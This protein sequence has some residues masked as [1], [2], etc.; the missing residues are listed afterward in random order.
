MGC[1]WLVIAGVIFE[2]AGFVLVAY[3]LTRIQRREFGKPAVM[4]RLR[5]RMGQLIRRPSVQVEEAGVA[6]LTG[7][8]IPH[9]ES[10]AQR[11]PED[12]RKARLESLEKKTHQLQAEVDHRNA[13]FGGDIEEPSKQLEKTRA[14]LGKVRRTIVEAQKETLRAS[15]ALRAWGT[16]LF[17]I[18]AI[19]SVVG[20]AVSC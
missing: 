9:T 1:T 19:L 11:S 7:K 14:E 2:M 12:A 5:A 6:D 18:G 20:S 4:R 3:E 16:A 13:T 17:A 10:E 8:G 15:V